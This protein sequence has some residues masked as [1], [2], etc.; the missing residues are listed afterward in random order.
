M[1]EVQRNLQA[2]I[3]RMHA[4]AAAAA[5]ETA[6]FLES[7]AKQNA[8]FTDRTGNLRNSID[9]TS[10]A[11]PDGYRMVLS[12]NMTYAPYVELGHFSKRN[13]TRMSTR[14]GRVTAQRISDRAFGTAVQARAF[15]WPT[16][17]GASGTALEIFKRHLHL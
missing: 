8:P 5:D 12:A 17:A 15:I 6:H 10:T 4:Q 3:Q 9:G 11:L 7:T 1:G 14:K 13:T 2:A 16:V